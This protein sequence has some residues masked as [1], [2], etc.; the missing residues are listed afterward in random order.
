[1]DAGGDAGDFFKFGRRYRRLRS[2]GPAGSRGF[3]G[4]GR[5]PALGT[6]HLGPRARAGHAKSLDKTAALAAAAAG[7]AAP[8]AETMER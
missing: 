2:T 3:S 1:M 7:G 8:A 5:L 6:G 4:T